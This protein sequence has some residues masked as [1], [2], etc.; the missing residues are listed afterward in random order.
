MLREAYLD[1][2]QTIYD[3]GTAPIDGENIID[4]T[5][6]GMSYYNDFLNPSELKYLQTHKNL[7]GEIIKM[8]P[9][10]YFERCAR[11]IF[12]NSVSSLIAQREADKRTNNLLDRVL[13]EYKLKLCL[14]MIN[15]ADKG[16]EGLHRMLAIARNYGWD[17]S[18]PVLVVDYFDKERA[19]QEQDKAFVLRLT[20]KLYDAVRNAIQYHYNNIEEFKQELEEWCLEKE[21]EY[22]DDVK[23]PV[24]V[25]I[26]EFEDYYIVR[27][28]Q[29]S[30]VMAE[31]P[32]YA[33]KLDKDNNEDSLDL[34]DFDLDD[35]K[36]SFS[37]EFLFH[38]TSNINSILESDTLKLGRRYADGQAVCLTRS[39]SFASRFDYIIVLDRRKLQNDYSLTLKSDSKN[40]MHK[41][42]SRIT[43]GQSKA[44]E[45]S[46]RDIQ[47]L[48]RYIVAIVTDKKLDCDYKV[49]PKS[50]LT[51]FTLTKLLSESYDADM[52][53]LLTR[54]LDK[55]V[56]CYFESS[57]LACE[58]ICEELYYEHNL[59]ATYK[60]RTIYIN[61]DKIA[62][63]RAVKDGPDLV[64]ITG[65]TLYI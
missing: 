46:L 17:K 34:D 42:F 64:A 60:G 14:P 9:R 49:V 15:Y 38:G 58:Q 21:F 50:G 33:V 20:N 26:E 11:D 55:Y 22:E 6:T 18:V 32:K 4:V 28:K 57:K 44:E 35:L 61:N 56:D 3:Y 13:N 2:E 16:Q 27:L 48:H 37:N 54:I 36:E 39:F 43:N 52:K 51:Q 1:K 47:N 23:K 5:K 25:N 65:Y 63:L 19:K 8:T 24:K 59:E 7:T 53:G 10:E 41:T 31:V 62:T 30:A 40:M 29:F 45:V 12:N